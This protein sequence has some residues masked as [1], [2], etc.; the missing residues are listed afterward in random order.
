QTLL[1]V[2]DVE[3]A[4]AFYERVFGM[5]RTLVDPSGIYIALASGG[6][7]LAFADA[8]WVAGN[9]LAFAPIDAHAQP[10]AVEI[11]VFVDDVESRW[12]AAIAAG[13]TAWLAP[14]PQPWGQIVAYVRDPNGF[15]V[16]IATFPPKR[17]RTPDDSAARLSGGCHCGNLTV[18][19]EPSRPLAA[20]AARACTCTFCAP[21]RLRWTSDPEG[22]V[23]IAIADERETSRY[24]FGT[25]TADFLVCRRC[26]SVVA[27]VGDGSP[28]LAVINI[29]VLDRA[30]DFADAEPRSFDGE[31]V[32]SR[33]ARRARSWTPATV[34]SASV[35]QP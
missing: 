17:P 35:S 24:R 32:Q 31:D 26:G 19:F 7:T 20:L 13:A 22:R 21:R 3:Q 2:S 18:S 12:R 14:T 28:L 4:A 10:S 1:Y 29:D 33:L 27:A 5:T 25:S 16:E 30:G 6:A 15:L 23:E 9:G 34:R 11:N 8:R